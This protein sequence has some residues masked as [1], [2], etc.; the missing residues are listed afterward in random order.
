MQVPEG[1]APPASRNPKVRHFNFSV[2]PMEPAH[3]GADENGGGDDDS[4]LA[5]AFASLEQRSAPQDY[6]SQL[7][8]K[9]ASEAPTVT[10]WQEPDLDPAP[11]ERQKSPSPEREVVGDNND[12]DDAES[13]KAVETKKKKNKKKKKKAKHTEEEEAAAEEDEEIP[14]DTTTAAAAA[15]TVVVAAANGDTAKTKRPKQK[16]PTR[17]AKHKGENVRMRTISD[18]RTDTPHAAHKTKAEIRVREIEREEYFAANVE[19]FVLGAAVRAKPSPSD[20]KDQYEKILEKAATLPLRTGSDK[21]CIVF[22]DQLLVDTFDHLGASSKATTVTALSSTDRDVLVAPTTLTDALAVSQNSTVMRTTTADLYMVQKR[23][24]TPS[25]VVVPPAS[26]PFTPL[27][28][29]E[30]DRIRSVQKAHCGA[31][32]DED[33]SLRQQLEEMRPSILNTQ[34]AV[35]EGRYRAPLLQS[36]APIYDG[37]EGK[38]LHETSESKAALSFIMRAEDLETCLNLE[39]TARAE[40]AMCAYRLEK[41]GQRDN[42]RPAPVRDDGAKKAK[43]KPVDKPVYASHRGRTADPFYSKKK[44]EARVSVI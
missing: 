5:S 29:L 20:A 13:S 11:V 33:K 17:D 44:V 28:Q 1:K 25:G 14:N 9:L 37:F 32:E 31:D 4:I 27:E 43:K 12:D 21:M 16:P 8:A 22:C 34:L 15:A 38:V 26:R 19:S 7:Q 18:Q 3:Q 6:A 30:L 10:P 41:E 23:M 42:K 39:C 35:L 24:C 40:A 2:T 36:V